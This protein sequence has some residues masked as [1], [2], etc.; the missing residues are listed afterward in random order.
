MNQTLTYSADSEGS[1]GNRAEV[2]ELQ[3]EC[4]TRSLLHT[5]P[6]MLMLTLPRRGPCL[7]SSY[8]LSSE[9][10]GQE[11][12]IFCAAF[13][14]ID[15]DGSVI[16]SIELHLPKHTIPMAPLEGKKHCDPHPTK[17]CPKQMTKFPMITENLDY[18][19]PL[20]EPSGD[21][22]QGST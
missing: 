9:L 16:S 14:V 12:I 3:T 6:E 10:G 2:K 18:A 19:S 8:K 5:Q 1:H 7:V 13:L 15:L 20:P 17:G 22:F 4:S 21:Y 11:D